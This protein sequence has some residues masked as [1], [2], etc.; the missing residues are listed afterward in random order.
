MSTKQIHQ[1]SVIFVIIGTLKNIGFK[2]ERYLCNVCHGLMQKAMNFND[3]A[4]ASIK[5]SD[6]RINFW[7]VSKN[8]AINIMNNS[9]LDE[10]KGVLYFF[11]YVQK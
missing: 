2:C 5:G 4:I 11:Y 7:H 10:K 8:D 9:N 3:V 1:K 6:Y